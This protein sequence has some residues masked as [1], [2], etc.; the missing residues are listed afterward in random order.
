MS[1][2]PAKLVQSVALEIGCVGTA[3]GKFNDADCPLMRLL[4]QCRTIVEARGRG[5]VVA[6]LQD[7]VNQTFP[8]SSFLH[9]LF[10]QT[11]DKLSNYFAMS[12]LTLFSSFIADQYFHVMKNDTDD[13]K[14]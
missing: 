7:Y 5:N 11:R 3:L 10:F 14:L 8:F 13:A 6:W 4:R 2:D 12:T 1:S 9:Y